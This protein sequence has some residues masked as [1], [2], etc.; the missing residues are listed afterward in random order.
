MKP[1]WSILY[2]YPII[3]K[4]F[5]IY[6]M[7]DAYLWSLDACSLTSN[8]S[9]SKEWIKHK[10]VLCMVLYGFVRAIDQLRYSLWSILCRFQ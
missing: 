5:F 7:F 2:H 3:T 9:I 1:L 8:F 4:V 6:S 10:R